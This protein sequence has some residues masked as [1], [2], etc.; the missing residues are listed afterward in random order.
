[1]NAIGAVCNATPG[2]IELS[3][4]GVDLVRQVVAEVVSVASAKGLNIDES[5]VNEMVKMSMRN[6]KTH[7]PSMLQDIEAGRPTEIDALNGAVTREA[8]RLGLSVPV[9][10][11]LWCLVKIA[12]TARAG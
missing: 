11:T 10:A 12:E 5:A 9:T 8:K 1:M 6:H 7:K 2:I 3:R 4:I